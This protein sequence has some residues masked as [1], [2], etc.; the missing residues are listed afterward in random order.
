MTSYRHVAL[1]VPD[2]RSAEEHYLA[3]FEMEVLFREAPLEAGGPET[4]RWGSLRPDVSW[5]D[6]ESAGVEIGMVAL[7]NDLFILPLFSAPPTGVQTYAIGL[8][9][10]RDEIE[11]VRN[12]LPDDATVESQAD[13]WLAFVDRFGVRWQLS[14]SRPFR[15][16]G[17]RNGIWVDV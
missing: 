6:A 13:G 11:A 12:R 4:E 16:A 2:L 5:D 15:G 7:Q 9:M 8:V 14:D 3:L 10:T 17:E 1:L